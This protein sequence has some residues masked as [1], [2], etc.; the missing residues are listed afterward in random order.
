MDVDAVKTMSGSGGRMQ[1][2][3]GQYN[4]AAFL[5]NEE[6]KTLLKER[7]C[8]NCHMQGHMSKQCPKKVKMVPT[9][10]AIRTT[11]AEPAPAYE[12][13]SSPREQEGGQGSTFDLIQSMND[14]E[15][16]KLLDNLCAEQGF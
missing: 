13:P 16:T 14:E 6:R 2:Q 7:R 11:E 4:R 1:P 15:R 9:T 8:F 5:T 10:P 3:Q 12:G